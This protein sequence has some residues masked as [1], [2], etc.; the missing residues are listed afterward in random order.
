MNFQ[1]NHFLR[2]T[3]TRWRTFQFQKL[4]NQLELNDKQ[5]IDY[6]STLDI[7]HLYDW[8]KP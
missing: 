8:R 3:L 5:F 2:M 6:M 1:Q 7:E 4:E